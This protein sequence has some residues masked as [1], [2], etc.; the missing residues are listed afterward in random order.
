MCTWTF[1]SL[2]QTGEGS[3]Y[4]IQESPT[5]Q[6]IDFMRIHLPIPS[7]PEID[8]GND[9][10]QIPDQLISIF[11]CRR[12][13]DRKLRQ[14]VWSPRK[15]FQKAYYSIF[16]MCTW[17]FSSLSEKGEGSRYNSR[18]PNLAV[19]QFPSDTL[20]HPLLSRNRYGKRLLKHPRPTV[21]SKCL[22]AHWP[23]TENVGKMFAVFRPTCQ[24]SETQIDVVPQTA[25]LATKIC[26]PLL[27]CSVS[28]QPYILT[29]WKVKNKEARDSNY[30]Q[31]ST[32]KF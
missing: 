20:A 14:Y 19:H 24:D 27:G 13:S 29:H 5:W 4:T 8:V 17:T 2:S 16:W 1:S 22:F 12:A 11:V 30:Y 26:E 7:Y 23:L 6:C 18:E 10:W 28:K 32:C 31:E 25:W 15:L 9:F 21:F 3:R